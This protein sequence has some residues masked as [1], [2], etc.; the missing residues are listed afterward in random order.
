MY[1]ILWTEFWVIKVGIAAWKEGRT[2][3]E[4]LTQSGDGASPVWGAEGR[5]ADQQLLGRHLNVGRSGQ[6]GL[7]EVRR[8]AAECTQVRARG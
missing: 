6:C 3:V 2:A 8:R 7:D 5:N 4:F 1:P